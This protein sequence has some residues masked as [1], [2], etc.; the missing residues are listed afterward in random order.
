MKS[1]RPA[2]TAAIGLLV[3]VRAASGRAEQPKPGAVH[4]TSRVSVVEVPVQVIGRDGKPVRGLGIPDFELEVDG[5]AQSISSV[6][7]VSLNRNTPVLGGA[8]LP[9]AGRRHFLFLFDFT[10]AT[11]NEIARSRDAAIRFVESG[12]SPDDFAAVATVSAESGLALDLTFTPDRRQIAAA[13]RRVGLPTEIDRARDPLAF[14]FSQPGDPHLVVQEAYSSKTLAV[15]AQSTQ[16]IMAAVG[17]RVADDY[18]LTRVVRHLSDMGNLARAL[19]LV[20]G[21]KTVL[22]FSEGFDSRL[23][24][25]SVAHE[26]SPEQTAADN[27]AILSGAAWSIDFD[28][29]Y[30]NSPMQKQ[31]ADTAELLRRSDCVVYPVDIAGLRSSSDGTIAPAERGEDFL[32]A[33][34]HGTGGE[35]I[36]NG[37]DLSTQIAR[38]EE[39]TSLTYVL[40]YSSSASSDG[41]YHPIRVRTRVKGARVSARPGYYDRP[42]FRGLTPLQRLMSAGNVIAHEKAAG[43]FPLDVLAFPLSSG[44]IAQLPVVVS[45]PQAALRGRDPEGRARL[46][47]YAY[48]FDAAGQM[49]DYFAR[50]AVVEGQRSP[51]ENLLFAGTCHVVPGK[52]RVRVYVRNSSDGRF[53]FAAAPVDVPEFGAVRLQALPPLFVKTG[54]AEGIVRDAPSGGDA[55]P[56]TIAGAPFVP[57]LSPTLAP[58]SNPHVCL[59]LVAPGPEGS[60][61]AFDVELRIVGPA[62]ETIEPSG[63]HVLG[64]TP[65]TADGVVKVL[66]DFTTANLAPGR[67]SFHVT[68]RDSTDRAIR[69]ES[70][71]AFRVS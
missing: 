46:E 32:F 40:S 69:S 65:R 47:V 54:G 16:K 62:G 19:D 6:D 37:N 2:V 18:M 10:F 39:K 63:V 61:P 57:D 60:I 38:V 15:D 59:M 25:G 4:E 43:D 1:F 42:S 23:I 50:E 24:F 52:Y 51:V 33:L 71:T 64:R 20:E 56:F 66:L 9:A 13:V 7:V 45:V 26:K 3:L 5:R 17:Q 49:V 29:R 21:R 67:Y 14:A 48:A 68:F 35:L 36:R 31:L 53:G 70:E 12:M 34:A 44:R 8:D 30:A 11:P 55:D 28:R 58:G 22:Y 27:D 41:K